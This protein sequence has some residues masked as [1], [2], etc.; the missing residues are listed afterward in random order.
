MAEK[1]RFPLLLSEDEHHAL[2]VAAAL[3]RTTMTDFVREAIKEKIEREGGATSSPSST[4][5]RT[6]SKGQE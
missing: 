4:K 1:I 3:G 5:P 6:E 2:R